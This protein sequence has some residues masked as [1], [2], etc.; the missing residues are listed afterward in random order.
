MGVWIIEGGTYVHTY[1][2]TYVPMYLRIVCS[3]VPMYICTYIVRIYYVLVCTYSVRNNGQH[4]D[5]VQPFW[6]FVRPKKVWVRHLAEHYLMFSS[7]TQ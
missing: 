3:Y 7:R 2:R 6:H 1:L 5:I 4:S